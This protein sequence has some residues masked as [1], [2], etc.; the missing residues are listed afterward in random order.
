ME[1]KVKFEADIDDILK[2]LG[3]LPDQVKQAGAES[4]RNLSAEMAKSAGEIRSQLN[5][6]T[7]SIKQIDLKIN[8]KAAQMSLQELDKVILEQKKITTEFERDLKSLEKQLKDTPKSA[9]AEQRALKLQIDQVREALDDQRISLRELG[10]EKA[11]VKNL[12]TT[13]QEVGQQVLAL[14]SELDA[15]RNKLQTLDPN[16]QD[17]K[18]LSEVIRLS[19]QNL[20]TFGQAANQ[21]AEKQVPLKTQLRELKEA[22]QQLE[23]SGQDTTQEFKDM[24]LEAGK[25]QDQVDAT[26]QRIKILS[27]DTQN[28]D[29]GLSAIQATTAAVQV[30]AGAWVALGGSQEKAQEVTAKLAALLNITNG[31]QQIQLAIQKES[32]LRVLGE[33]KAKALLTKVQGAYTI[34]VGGSTGALKALRV[35]LVATGIGAL[36]ISVGLLIANFDKLKAAVSGVSK[37]DKKLLET[38]KERTAEAEKQIDK[39][40]DQD[41]ILKLQGKSEREILGLKRQT[42]LEGIKALEIELDRQESLKQSQIDASK[43]NQEILS[44]ILRGLTLPLQVII[45]TVSK[46]ARFFGKDFDFNIGEKLAGLVFNPERV[47]EKADKTIELTREKLNKLKNDEAGF[48]LSLRELDKKAIE[49]KKALAQKEIDERKKVLDIIAKLEDD[50][51]LSKL[52]DEA[53]EIE[54]VKRKYD[55]IIDLAKK[56]NKDTAILEAAKLSELKAI[57]EKF[58]IEREAKAN[59]LRLKEFEK[60]KED[61]N[62]FYNE[63]AVIAKESFINKEITEKEF[64]ERLKEIEAER[65]QGLLLLNED[66]GESIND[67]NQTILDNQVE[68]TKEALKSVEDAIAATSS[69]AIA[70]GNDLSSNL[71]RAFQNLDQNYQAYLQGVEQGT[72][73][74]LTKQEF[75]QKKFARATLQTALTA[76][77]NELR[78]LYTTIIAKQVSLLGPAGFATGAASVAALETAF[79]LAKGKLESFEKGTEYLNVQ[80][81]GVD[82]KGGR[83]I[84]AHVGERIVPKH[85]N[86]QLGNIRNEDLPKFL[87]QNVNHTYQNNTNFDNSDVVNRSDIMIGELKLLRKAMKNK[88]INSRNG[89]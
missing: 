54:A 67:L 10:N 15:I 76:A 13:F 72:N 26:Q 63:S 25:L 40:N 70:V 56:N 57:Q 80:G 78:L 34:A 64:N 84:I 39:M 41:N 33:A 65:L 29:L 47:E 8:S 18:E 17:F 21:T 38:D 3:T 12:D 73:E 79:A 51:F 32:T 1:Y 52:S 28:I 9:L 23:L 61:L 22:M 42:V 83:Q 14:D 86:S 55:E 75:A 81:R 2:E 74:Y 43:R 49:D 89:F 77:Q 30:G 11:A 69:K 82:G 24:Q 37:Q 7:S 35:A 5:K 16:S 85:I 46:V 4:S 58:D 71:V 19:E 62:T 20:K 59:E 44:S 45:D 36:I 53:K 27:S 66:Y 60:S 6:V 87:K 31:L 50:Y 88:F 68:K 48:Q